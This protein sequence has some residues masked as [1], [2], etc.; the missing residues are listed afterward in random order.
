MFLK[1]VELM[2]FKSFADRTTIDFTSGIT[3]LLGPNGCGKSNVVDAIKWVLG[4]QSTR[5][6]RAERMEDVIFSG[7]QERKA[8]NVAEV[9][10]LISNEE[11][12]LDLDLPELFI[13]RRLYR[14]GD[15]EYYLN[16][17]PIKLK[18][19]R[20]LFYD[21]GIGK[22]AY[23]IMEQ[24]KIDQ[25]LSN[26]PEER[27]HLF[28]EAA[29]ITRF[30]VRGSEAGRKLAKTRENIFQVENIL[31][32]VRRN[33]ESLKKQSE[34]T[35]EYRR[36]RQELN[37]IDIDLLLL[38]YQTLQENLE[39]REAQ[40]KKE[41]VKKK[42]LEEEIQRISED[43]ASNIDVLQTMESQLIE[44]QKKLYGLD[45]EKEGISDRVRLYKEQILELEK[46]TTQLKQQEREIVERKVSL[47]GKKESLKEGLQNLRD[48]L[49]ELENNA[50]GLEKMIK[51]T[52]EE[53]AKN[54]QT[55]EAMEKKI[56]KAEEEQES[57][58]RDLRSLTDH[59]V[60]KLDKDLRQSG[61]S[62]TKKNK[63]LEKINKEIQGMRIQLEGKSQLFQD[64]LQ[65]G[66]DQPHPHLWES[67]I[68]ALEEIQKGLKALELWTEELTKSLPNFLEEFLAPEG[69]INKKREIDETLEKLTIDLKG[70]RSTIQG[71]TKESRELQSKAGELRKNLEE[72]RVDSAKTATQ[73]AAIEDNI[74]T[75]HKEL[76]NL[77]EQIRQSLKKEGHLEQRKKEVLEKVTASQRDIQN[78]DESKKA[79]QKDLK[80]LE[81][82]IAK[83]TQ[84]RSGEEGSLKE[85]RGTLQNALLSLE[86]VN[87]EREHI[88][89]DIEE[90]RQVFQENHSADISQYLPRLKAFKKSR[91]DLKEEHNR[92]KEALRELGQVNLMALEEFA[93]AKDR[94][95]FLN[96]QLED[97]KQADIHLQQVTEDIQRESAELF[98]RTYEKVRKNFDETFRLL[99][100]GGRGELKL[101]NP[102]N[103]LESGIE[104][105]AQPPGKKLENISL[106][107]GGERSLAGVALL[108]A[109]YKVK[110]SPFC[111]LDEIDA[112]LDEANIQRFIDMLAEF[113]EQSQFVIITH[114]KRTV[115]GAQTLLGVTME[116]SGVSKLISMRIGEAASA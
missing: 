45:L 44:D 109:T 81:R 57:L 116:E 73:V 85:K 79:L 37:T 96:N 76:D 35:K 3:A 93:E 56:Q 46:Q 52:E 30:R 54:S 101:V 95:E 24:G 111:I 8:L 82:S 18:E 10:L 74:K 61:Y 102:Q 9:T 88:Q 1:R 99:F 59:I 26:K 106:L 15:S 100:G 27:R 62:V 16:G 25:V 75:L 84:N 7:T 34:K 40:R 49:K 104:I 71:K 60:E 77:D 22:S 55:I 92:I 72:L 87:L 86:K 58:Q 23:S 20:E 114:N 53:V 115:T 14:E 67:G 70:C 107:S 4:E 32:E 65:V 51:K 90:L 50:L 69:I 89:R 108:F 48:L 68:Q 33:Y 6:M 112:A 63:L 12:L 64:S 39:K 94:Y 91:H 113:A 47:R 29:G 97:L 66:A 80:I 17:A 31:R 2:G 36:L 110:S 11:N 41:G 105:Y 78:H 103:P 5:N 98:R 43:L 83:R 42:K 21:T 13:K 19:L 38:K 28:E